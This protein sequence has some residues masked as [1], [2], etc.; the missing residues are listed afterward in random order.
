VL[1][2]KLWNKSDAIKLDYESY[3]LTDGGQMEAGPD[4]PAFIVAVR[5]EIQ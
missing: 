5:P 2:L 3:G 4:V 1:K